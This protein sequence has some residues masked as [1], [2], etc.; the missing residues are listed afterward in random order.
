MKPDEIL[1]KVWITKYA[2]TQ[3][4]Y[5]LENAVRSCDYPAMIRDNARFTSFFHGEGR[6]WHLTEASALAHA[7]GMRTAKIDALREQIAKLEKMVF[8]VK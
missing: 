7:D 4:V 6:E 3:G 1:P 5:T 2:L 8:A